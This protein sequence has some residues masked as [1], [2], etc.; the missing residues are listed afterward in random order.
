MDGTWG[1]SQLNDMVMKFLENYDKKLKNLNSNCL[2]MTCFKIKHYDAPGELDSL[3][4]LN[5][6]HSKCGLLL[7]RG[8]GLQTLVTLGDNGE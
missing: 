6:Q 5:S 8:S 7:G 1:Q 3:C 2:R 4:H